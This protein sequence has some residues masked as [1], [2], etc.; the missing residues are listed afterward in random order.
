M[1]FFSSRRRHTRC[2]LVTGVQTCALPIFARPTPDGDPITSTYG[3]AYQFDATR[4]APYLRDY[5]VARGTVR[6]EGKVV[7]VEQHP[8]TG[9]VTALHLE[10]GE[11]VTGD[12]FIDCSGFRSLLLGDTLQTPWEDWSHWLPCDRAAALPCESPAGDIEPLTTAIAMPFGWRWR[13][14]LQQIG[15]TSWRERGVQH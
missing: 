1:F 13:I 10:S 5:A 3:Y 9:D 6:T 12:L 4:F 8:E 2:A 15:R 7:R 14:P 11:T